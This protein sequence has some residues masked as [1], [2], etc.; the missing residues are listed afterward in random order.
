MSKVSLNRRWLIPLYIGFALL[1]GSY[2]YSAPN[3][4]LDVV[5]HSER[6]STAE[7]YYADSG[8]I[9]SQERSSRHAY[10]EG[11]SRLLLPINQK[12]ISTLRFD[13][14][15]ADNTVTVTRLR[16]IDRVGVI[17]DKVDFN[18]V[19]AGNQMAEVA[20]KNGKLV[21][22]P[23][24]GSS[25]PYVFLDIGNGLIAR[26]HVGSPWMEL[27]LLF[28]L[29][30]YLWR[31]PAAPTE[32]SALGAYA[33]LLLA[34]LCI[35]L[36]A[37]LLMATSRSVNP[38]ETMHIGAARF[39]LDNWL[40]P[41]VGDS[42]VA[43][44]P[45]AYGPWGFSYLDE[46]DV[47]YFFAG[48]FAVVLAPF[49]PDETIR[50]RLFNV[51]ILFVLVRICFMKKWA[52]PMAPLLLVSPQI[53][54]VFSYF[55]GDAFA[56]GVAC[57]TVF[58]ITDRSFFLFDQSP[59]PSFSWH[60]WKSAWRQYVA[61]AA[62]IS[63]VIL[64]KRNFWIAIPFVALIWSA[65]IGL[66]GRLETALTAITLLAFSVLSL[67]SEH[68]LS[69]TSLTTFSVIF[70]VSALLLCLAVARRIYLRPEL[71]KWFR[72][73]SWK[74]ALIIFLV[75]SISAPRIVW[76]RFIN[77]SSAEK[78]ALQITTKNQYAVHDLKPDTIKQG[79]GLASNRLK[80]RG[81]ALTTLF[82]SPWNWHVTTVRSF[83]GAY[84]YMQYFTADSIVSALFVLAMTLCG[85]SLWRAKREEG[86]VE[87]L[88]ILAMMIV[89]IG[90]SILASWIAGFQ[91]QG[92]Y[93]FALLPF[94]FLHLNTRLPRPAA[95]VATALVVLSTALGVFGFLY[96]GLNNLVR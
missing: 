77:G 84:G 74:M 19:S 2:F 76:D 88:V 16:V 38:D 3:M 49:I 41:A 89:V 51:L 32:R 9:L 56:L 12:S 67:E 55:S 10:P 42:R 85:L 78:A 35:V 96:Y 52:L 71:V 59:G 34:V 25:D 81:V 8:E 36:L 50:F 83:F 93:L 13:P 27:T 54:Y 26:D 62:L 65:R 66:I 6:S 60:Y 90:S 43:S 72:Q 31:Q 11:E 33:P 94:A 61:P 92:R 28:F 24:T 20:V 80:D 68:S 48:K 40:P 91:A 7:V 57:L 53:W 75:I 79:G 69:K 23:T 58:Y 87:P 5:I 15:Q 22:T 29:G 39:Y 44:D 30:L 21:L 17:L 64:A 82:A 73:A 14:S 45:D 70:G 47:C 1:Y 63:L 86:C 18:G 37:A 4:Y 95:D 46:W